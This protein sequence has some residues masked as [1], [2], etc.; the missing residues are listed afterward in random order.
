MCN[1]EQG[2]LA[3]EQCRVP[4]IVKM[5]RVDENRFGNDVVFALRAQRGDVELFRMRIGEGCRCGRK[6]CGTR[7][8]RP[9]A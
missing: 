4:S 7:R 5:D 1:G 2:H 9:K 8:V 6:R 3:D